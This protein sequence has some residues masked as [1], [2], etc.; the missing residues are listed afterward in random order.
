MNTSSSS[1]PGLQPQWPAD[2]RPWVTLVDSD[3]PPDA[4]ARPLNRRRV[5]IPVIL[6]AC[7]VLVVVALSGSA[8]ARRL[9]EREAVADAARRATVL[10]EAVVQPALRNGLA[11]QDPA[12]VREVH[13]VVTERVMS[14]DSIVRVK[15]WTPDG[16]IVYS[17]EQRLVGRQFDLPDEEWEVLT[18]PKTR[19]EVSDLDG[20]EN[21]FERGEGRLLEVYRPVWLPNRDPLLLE[22]Y[23]KYDEVTD[24]TGELWRGFAGITLSSLLALIVLMLPVLWRLTARLR[25]VQEQREALVERA[26]EASIDERRRIAGN[27][28]DGVIQDLAGA[29]LVVSSA[30]ARAAAAKETELA[31]SLRGAS[32]T[33]R[34]GITS[35]RSL[36]VDI[37]PPNLETAGLDQTLEGLAV[38]LRGRDVEVTLALDPHAAERLDLSQQQLVYRVAHETLRNANLHARPAHVE[39]R[40]SD[41]P[42]AVVLE[43]SDDGAGF[44]AEAARAAP[45]RGHF[46][47]QV[48]AD[49]AL[50]AGAD[51]AVASRPGAGTRWVLRIPT[52]APSHTNERPRWL[53]VRSVRDADMVGRRERGEVAY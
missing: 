13:E 39:V 46:G 29:S 8:A 51:L 49:V 9:A 30:A 25:Q 23:S 44:D 21:Q 26:V 1:R 4:D 16:T 14:D 6:G 24:R 2:P 18:D 41:E 43:I 34:A 48:L 12:A 38:S 33:V 19:A 36:L 50:D 20:R 52:A 3:A 53:R 32:S 40:L 5:M 42:T 28:H 11:R 45:E 37:Y 31:T 15:I 35:M 22:I 7:L 47:L 27:L 17:D 10:A